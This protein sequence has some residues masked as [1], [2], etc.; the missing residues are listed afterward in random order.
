MFNPILN[1]LIARERYNDSLR[2][3]ERGQLAKAAIACRP[4]YRFDLRTHLG[5]L[6]IAVRH[7]FKALAHA[8]KEHTHDGFC[9]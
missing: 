7:I 8:N 4:A 3:A 6:L 9:P 5:N 1:E 2:E